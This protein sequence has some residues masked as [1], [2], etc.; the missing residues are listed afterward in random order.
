MTDLISADDSAIFAK[1]DADAADILHDT[2]QAAKSYGMEINVDKTKVLTTDGS[3]TTVHLEG[4]QIEQVQEFKCLGSLV[5]DMKIA[6]TADIRSRIGRATMA[7]ASV[8][9]SLWR[10]YNI[11]METKICLYRMLTLSILLY[12]SETSQR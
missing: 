6:S 8:R 1:G 3:R 9:W 7:F 11:S 4:V 5:Q 2:A 12:G 10:K